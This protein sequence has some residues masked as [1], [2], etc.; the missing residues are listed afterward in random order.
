M[1]IAY[2]NTFGIPAQYRGFETCV[3][4]IAT[5]LVKKGHSVTV[6][7]ASDSTNRTS[8]YRGV[9]LINVPRSRNKFLDYPI[10]SLISTLDAM[11]RDFDIL[12]YYGTDSAIFTI[13]PR[14]LSRKVV[15]SLDGRAWNR[16]SYPI[17]VRAALWLSSWPALYLPQATT[18]DSRCVGEWYRSRCGKAPIFVPYG[19]KVSPRGADP[20]VLRRFGLETDK[21][22]LFVGALIP[23]KG[24]HYIIQ[25]F[26]NIESAFQLVIVGGN[27]YDSS[28]ERWLRKLAGSH[29]K[30]LGTVWGSDMENLFMGAYLCVNAS[31][32]EGTSPALLSAMGCG[33]CAVVSDIPENLETIGNAG[34]S[35]R[36]KDP[37]DLRNKIRL[38]LSNA[39]IVEDHRKKAVDR[40]TRLYSWDSIANHMERVY[41]S[42]C[43]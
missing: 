7:C 22:L 32:T 25:A 37:D 15:M 20:N 6:Y 12:H 11:S 4:E 29:V 23:E 2:L 24:V 5:R 36:N 35:F 13:I 3:E 21:Y 40:V 26:N 43:P 10:R 31:E 42:L 18:V 9:R 34:L 1:R 41:L 28:Y 39:D 16:F 27:P 30:F 17:W 19:A 38:L 33:N 14:V 8:S